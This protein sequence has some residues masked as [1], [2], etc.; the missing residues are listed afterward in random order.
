MI[1]LVATLGRGPSS[2]KRSRLD[3]AVDGATAPVSG[4]VERIPVHVERGLNELSLRAIETPAP[5]NPPPATPEQF[6][7]VLGLHAENAR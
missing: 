3:V 7:A 4:R 6:V 2:A 1:D 5:A